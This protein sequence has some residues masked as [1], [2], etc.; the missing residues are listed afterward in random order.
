MGSRTRWGTPIYYQLLGGH[1]EPM[2]ANAIRAH[3]LGALGID[4]N[5]GCP[6]K[7]VNKN[8]GG[9]TLLKTPERI[10]S[11]VKLV[12]DSVPA[13]TP[14]TAKIRLGFDD[15]SQCLE[16]AKAAEEGGAQWLTVHARTKTDGYRPPAHW[17]WLPRIAE[18]IKIPVIAN[19]EVWT[20]DDYWRC[21]EVSGCSDVMIGRGEISNPMIFQQIRDSVIKRSGATKP[22]ASEPI[23]INS[24]TW[25]EVNRLLPGFF[26]AAETSKSG[27]FAQS[28][29]KQWLKSLSLAHPPAKELFERLK[30]ITNPALFRSELERALVVSPSSQ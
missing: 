28:R 21:R 9:A 26:A 1:P 30:V 17:E 14:V 22:L 19:G 12:R 29:T 13:I 20:V 8:D 23:E 25:P 24:N 18:T 6:A 4:L 5:F 2:A 10:Y 7:T 15:P 11:I 27:H 3:E 16:N